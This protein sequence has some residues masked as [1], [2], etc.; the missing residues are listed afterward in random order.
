MVKSALQSPNYASRNLAILEIM[1]SGDKMKNILVDTPK[2][3]FPTEAEIRV[4]ID[5]ETHK[6]F[7]KY[8]T[9]HRTTRGEVVKQLIG[10]LLQEDDENNK[11]I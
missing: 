11:S 8:C 3:V 6:R 1:K 9:K 4:N 2:T 7:V 10:R 5:V